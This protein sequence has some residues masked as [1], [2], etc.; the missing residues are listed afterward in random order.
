MCIYL[1]SAEAVLLKMPQLKNPWCLLLSFVYKALSYVL[2]VL[3]CKEKIR[4]LLKIF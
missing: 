3:H 1:V 2:Y 4:R